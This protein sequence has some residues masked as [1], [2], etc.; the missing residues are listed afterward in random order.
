MKDRDRLPELNVSVL[1]DAATE[2]RV[3][4]VWRRLESELARAGPRAL[5]MASAWAWA[6]AAVVIIFASGVFVGA[7]WAPTEPTVPATLT[8]EPI[9][10][11]AGP[12]AP[13]DLFRSPTAQPDQPE[14][15]KPS[16]RVQRAPGPLP[17]LEVAPEQVEQLV[18]TPA[19]VVQMKPEWQ[20]LS[21]EGQ[22]QE[23]RLAIEQEGGFDAVLRGASPEQLMLL[24]DVARDTGSAG[25]AIAALRRVVEQFPSDVNAPDAAYQLGVWLRKGG[26]LAG[27]GRAFATYR[28]L[29]PDGDFSEDALARQIEAAIEQGELELARQL[30]EQYAREFPTGDRLVEFQ[31]V[32]QGAEAAAASGSTVQESAPDATGSEPAQDEERAASAPAAGAPR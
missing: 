31:Q 22:F 15:R 23:A 14:R 29:S 28:A 19:P 18:Q 17:E 11:P 21:E 25:Q 3:E 9:Q 13:P 26:D 24:F 30:A 32:L 10:P 7:N 4:R 20:R 16:P 2:Q 1:R 8:A 27:A 6:P 12:T 5:R